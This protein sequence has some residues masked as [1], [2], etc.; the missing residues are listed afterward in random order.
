MIDEGL[1]EVGKSLILLTASPNAVVDNGVNEIG[2]RDG[3]DRVVGGEK[4]VKNEKDSIKDGGGKV[5]KGGKWVKN[6]E[7]D[8]EDGLEKHQTDIDQVM[9]STARDYDEEEEDED[10]GGDDD[11]D[12]AKMKKCGQK[13]QKENV[14]GEGGGGKVEKVRDWAKKKREKGEK[15][16]EREEREKKKEAGKEKRG[17]IGKSKGGGESNEQAAC[18]SPVYSDISD[19]VEDS[20]RDWS[21]PSSH[22]LPDSRVAEWLVSAPSKSLAYTSYF[23]QIL[24]NKQQYFSPIPF[25]PP[26][27]SSPTPFKPSDLSPPIPFK[28][29]HPSPPSS[30]YNTLPSSSNEEHS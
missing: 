15:G 5:K 1:D 26:H 17:E 9:T 28:P 29:S 27:P 20:L 8:K 22:H 7:E 6:E 13:V 30:S 3:I 16:A 2:V 19:P 23:Q 12:V 11:G 10:V 21:P 4:G 25:S 24:L 18:I 14:E